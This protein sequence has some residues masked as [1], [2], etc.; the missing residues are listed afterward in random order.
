MRRHLPLI[1]VAV[2]LLALAALGAV[3]RT[4]HA[5]TY[6]GPAAP[7]GWRITYQH[8]FATIPGL[9]DWVVQPGANA[10]IADYTHPGAEFG[11]GITLTAASQWE[12]VISSRAVV[13]PSSFVQGLI[14]I[15]RAASGVTANWPAFWTSNQPWPSSGEDDML[16]GTRGNSCFGTHYGATAVTEISA[17]GGCAPTHA[18]GVGWVTVSALR[19]NGE[20]TAW[21]GGVRI[22]TVPLP[23]TANERLQFQTQSQAPG[24]QGQSDCPQCFGPLTVPS[25]A[26][27]SRVTVWSAP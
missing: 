23:P 11:L 17:A 22:G 2:L 20:V 18:V 21:Y 19:E 6:I 27:L 5:G 10:R 14:F 13:G 25:T 7:A 12:E 4:A 26:Y 3:T 8:N 1:V 15:P 16:E 24:K 9:A